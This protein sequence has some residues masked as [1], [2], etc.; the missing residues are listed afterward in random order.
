MDGQTDGQTDDNQDNTQ[1][2]F[3]RRN[4]TSIIIM[5]IYFRSHQT[6]REPHPSHG[7]AL[8]LI[9][10]KISSSQNITRTKQSNDISL[11]WSQTKGYKK[12]THAHQPAQLSLLA[13][14]LASAL[15]DAILAFALHSTPIRPSRPAVSATR[16]RSLEELT[17]QPSMP[18]PERDNR[19]KKNTHRHLTGSCKK[20]KVTLTMSD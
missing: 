4:M 16:Y 14:N 15:L 11:L 19:K 2:F 3:P 1:S 17:A 13:V 12:Q 7:I 18:V 6:A 5:F 9:G 8:S 10:T 20:K